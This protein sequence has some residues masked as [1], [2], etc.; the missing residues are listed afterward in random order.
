MTPEQAK[1]L[2][3]GLPTGWLALVRFRLAEQG[4]HYGDPFI[5]RV[6]NGKK[7][8]AAIEEALLAVAL[9]EKERRQALTKRIQDAITH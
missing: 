7:Q 2:S 9:E 6:K 8:N 1:Q 5:S 4:L 3:P